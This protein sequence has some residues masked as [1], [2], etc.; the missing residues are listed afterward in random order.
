VLEIAGRRLSVAGTYSEARPG[1][2][3]ALVNSYGSLEVAVRAGSAARTLG[4]GAG[5]PVVLWK[6][7]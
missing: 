7:A 6:D 5:A 1:E 2:L 3:V 4:V